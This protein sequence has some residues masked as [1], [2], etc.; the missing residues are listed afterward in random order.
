MLN[1]EVEEATIL[2]LLD[3]EDRRLEQEGVPK[4]IRPLF[5]VERVVNRLGHH[6]PLYPS[7][8]KSPL[9]QRVTKAI[10]HLYPREDQQIEHHIG[11]AI[12]EDT[13]AKVII[14]LVI[15]NHP[16]QPIDYVLLPEIQKNRLLKDQ[17]SFKI[18]MDQ[19]SDVFDM[20]DRYTPLKENIRTND[21]LKVYLK[22]ARENMRS[23]SISV[24]NHTGY[25]GVVQSSL[26]ATELTLKASAIAIGESETVL[27]NDYGHN[28][29]KLIDKFNTDYPQADAARMRKVVNNWP[30]YVG[31]RYKS[32]GQSKIEDI[33]VL[34]G[35]QFVVAEV[36]RQLTASNFR[37]LCSTTWT[38]QYPKL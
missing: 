15:G 35:A 37:D 3:Q 20:D 2:K 32:S 38:R 24:A 5:I 18:V 28:L 7:S 25:Q 33:H 29:V 6:G 8:V 9:Q 16:F 21:I 14:P 10:N 19:F 12:Y 1:E 4:F 17:K 11:I 27:K 23:A 13:I 36:A 30:N 31:S 34:V 22:N 26:L